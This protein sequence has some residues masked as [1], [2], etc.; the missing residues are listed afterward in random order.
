M[1]TPSRAI[2]LNATDRLPA[3]L[4]RVVARLTALRAGD[5]RSLDTAIDD[6]VRELDA[7]RA[8]A[9]GL[10][11]E[12][13]EQLL[14][15]LRALDTSLI[16]AVRS[17]CDDGTLLQLGRDADAEL[18]A[19]RDRMPRDAYEQSRRACIDRLIRERSRLPVIHF[20]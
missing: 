7:A 12:A 5:D 4:E 15:R 16:D 8:G 1:W 9:K 10:R 13:R 6:T 2:R 11:G 14:A 3:H 17:R 18:A 19:F 20:E